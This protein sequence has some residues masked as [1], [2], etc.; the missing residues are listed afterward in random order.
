MSLLWKLQS[1]EP[2]CLSLGNKEPSEDDGKEKEEES[3]E[4]E[5][6]MKEKPSLEDEEQVGDG[7]QSKTVRFSL[8]YRGFDNSSSESSDEDSNDEA[9]YGNGTDTYVPS[10]FDEPT[11]RLDQ[12]R[13][14]RPNGQHRKPTYR[15]LMNS[16]MIHLQFMKRKKTIGRAISI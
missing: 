7:T 11:F 3:S 9:S 4:D 15:L 1:R 2:F 16:K 12:S 5:E 14:K 13:A 6:Q 8:R 10:K